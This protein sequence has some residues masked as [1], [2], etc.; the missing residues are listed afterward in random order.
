MDEFDRCVNHHCHDSF[1]FCKTGLIMTF[2]GV[3]RFK[4]RKS[5]KYLRQRPSH[6]RHRIED[7]CYY[8]W[9]YAQALPPTSCGTL[10]TCERGQILS[11]RLVTTTA[12][13]KAWRAVGH[14]SGHLSSGVFGLSSGFTWL[15]LPNVSPESVGG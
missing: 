8:S 2:W 4:E 15:H 6:G 3:L 1:L 13:A 9:F 5:P 14:H 11:S 7:S 12:K 10:L